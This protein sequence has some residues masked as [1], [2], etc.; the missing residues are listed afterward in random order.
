MR[1]VYVVA[2]PEAQ[3]HV[4]H[5]VGGWYDS[6]LTDRGHRHAGLIA[7][8]LRALV[9]TGE[10]VAVHSSDLVRARQTAGHVAAL[11]G[12]EP[13]LHP[14]L[15]EKSYGVA[16]GRP[17]AWLDSRFVPPPAEGNRMDHDEGVE[18]AETKRAFAER[19]YAA[20][21]TVAADPATHQVVVTHGFAVTFAIAAWI[22]V[23]LDAAGYVSFRS[24]SGGLTVL[25][26]DDFFHNRT[27]LS[28]NETAH[29]TAAE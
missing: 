10:S 21:A 16:E 3:H 29:L 8:R 4:D 11:L 22:R 15:R 24:T 18:G 12:V 5:L 25:G 20:M 28:L 17:Q 9:P 19:V 7:H 23:P 6:E 14:A 26:E 1:R 2:H 27:V 13:M